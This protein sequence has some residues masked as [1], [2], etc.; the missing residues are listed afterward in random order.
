MKTRISALTLLSTVVLSSSAL[1]QGWEMGPAFKDGWKP[2]FTVAA[3]VGSINIDDISGSETYTGLELS[4]N[5]PWFQP[6]S[7]TIRQQ[8]NLGNYDKNGIEVSAIEMNPNYFVTISPG[9]TWGFGPG[10]GYSRVSYL[11]G[12]SE[13]LWSVQ[14]STNL[15]YRNGAL[16]MGAGA[17]YQATQDD[18]I[19]PGVKGLDNWLFTA[20]VGLNF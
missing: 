16:F 5:C 19:A 13:G 1:A 4:L 11:N 14:A 7:G 18:T 10:I 12:P 6:P 17:R 2:E 20:K 15:N 9:L 8:F 3:V